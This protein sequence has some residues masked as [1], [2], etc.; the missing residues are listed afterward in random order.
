MI[1]IRSWAVASVAA[2]IVLLVGINPVDASKC[3]RLS[4]FIKFIVNLTH[5]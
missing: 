4:V 3:E 5:G 1:N 2:T